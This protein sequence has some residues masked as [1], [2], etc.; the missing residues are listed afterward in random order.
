MTSLCFTNVSSECLF[1]VNLCQLTSISLNL[2]LISI[3]VINYLLTCV[4]AATVASEVANTM[5]ILNMQG[6]K[7][8]K[9]QEKLQL[10]QTDKAKIS[11]LIFSVLKKKQIL[12]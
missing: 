4:K 1:Y 3:R 5:L 2:R 9:S 11:S 10:G 8:K 6:T 12:L 7:H